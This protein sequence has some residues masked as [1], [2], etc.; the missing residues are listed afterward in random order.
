MRLVVQRVSKSSVEV[1]G[2]I[3][4]SI[5]KGLLVLVGVTHKDD[6][7]DV[8]WLSKKLTKIR[9][10]SDKNDKM[11]YSVKDVEGDVLIVSQFT[12]FA[13]TKK[14]TRPSFTSAADPSRA[15]ALYEKFKVS[16]AANLEKN[17]ASGVFGADMK[18]SIDNDGPV[19]ILL[20]SK[21]R[22]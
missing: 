14:G 18:L 13:S 8:D 5:G 4:G 22:Y 9:L 6:E 2:K 11:N 20:D 7:S 19:T 16:V 15:E 12:L 10:F 1:D 17:I 21:N 3:A